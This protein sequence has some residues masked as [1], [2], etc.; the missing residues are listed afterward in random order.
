M[1]RNYFGTNYGNQTSFT[2]LP[3]KATVTTASIISF[4]NNSAVV[5]GNV[6]NSGGT[7]VTERGVY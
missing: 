4:I 5:G 3:S 6:T 2:T 7:T 1:Q